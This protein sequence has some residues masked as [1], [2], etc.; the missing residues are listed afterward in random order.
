MI[1]QKWKQGKQAR[2][3]KRRALED[4]KNPKPP[5]FV[6]GDMVYCKDDSKSMLI[7]GEIYIIGTITK[8]IMSS[9]SYWVSGK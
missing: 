3:I 7:F 8:N 1:S 4:Q 9:Y 2:L 5:E 6:T